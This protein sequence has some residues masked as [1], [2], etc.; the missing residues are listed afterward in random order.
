M[1]CRCT[2]R[3]GRDIPAL[4]QKELNISENNQELVA[5]ACTG[6]ALT[7]HSPSPALWN[8]YTILLK[9]CPTHLWT[10]KDACGVTMYWRK[11]GPIEGI[12][13]PVGEGPTKTHRI[14]LK[15]Q[16]VVPH[17]WCGFTCPWTIPAYWYPLTR[18]MQLRRN[19]L[20]QP[21]KC[22]LAFISMHHFHISH[23][24]SHFLL[25]CNSIFCV[26]VIYH[27]GLDLEVI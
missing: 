14:Q 11:N 25:F 4:P 9:F 3:G 16:Y 26:I 1:L 13:L 22:L 20:W 27:Y 18:S 8:L 17:H 23:F 21:I 7:L 12:V 15:V 6:Q 19:D 10:G 24:T 5:L 2:P